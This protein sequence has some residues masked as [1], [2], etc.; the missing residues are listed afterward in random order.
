MPVVLVALV[1]LPGA[2]KTT[3]AEALVRVPTPA[4][5]A[6]VT[7]VH[8]DVAAPAWAAPG[9]GPRRV[10]HEDDDK[11][12]DGPSYAAAR[13]AALDAATAALEA[14]PRGTSGWT[15]VLL[16]DVM[17]YASMRHTAY[18]AARRGAA[19]VRRRPSWHGRR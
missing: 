19:R 7:A 8:M 4:G 11:L 9:S 15:V 12:N 17:Y 2:G 13:Q 6:R 10:D 5:V 14:A 1:G 16:D 3:L 18:L